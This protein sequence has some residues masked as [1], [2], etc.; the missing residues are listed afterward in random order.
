LGARRQGLATEAQR[1]RAADS[2]ATPR[3]GVNGRHGLRWRTG[4]ISS[5]LVNAIRGGRSMGLLRRPSPSNRSVRT[6]RP[7]WSALL[8]VSV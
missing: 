3:S 4:S 1:H 6:A 8:C 5:R 7:A 2:T